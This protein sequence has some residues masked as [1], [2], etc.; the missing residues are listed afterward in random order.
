[1]AGNIDFSEGDFE[2][3][4]EIVLFLKEFSGELDGYL[5]RIN[6]DESIEKKDWNAFLI[7][8]YLS[9]INVYSPY[10]EISTNPLFPPLYKYILDIE[11]MGRPRAPLPSSGPALVFEENTPFSRALDDV[12]RKIFK[13][14][15]PEEENKDEEKISNIRGMLE[16]IFWIESK[17][18]PEER[19]GISAVGLIQVTS[20]VLRDDNIDLDIEWTDDEGKTWK[21]GE[22]DEYMRGKNLSGDS[23]EDKRNAAWTMILEKKREV[24]LQMSAEDQLTKIVLPYVKRQIDIFGLKVLESPL[25]MYLSVLYPK[26]LQ[27]AHLGEQDSDGKRTWILGS[28]ASHKKQRIQSVAKANPLHRPEDV[29]T[30][31]ERNKFGLGNSPTDRDVLRIWEVEEY[32]KRGQKTLEQHKEQY[33][34]PFL[35]KHRDAKRFSG[36]FPEEYER[37]LH[38]SFKS[39]DRTLSPYF[40]RENENLKETHH[41]YDLAY[42]ALLAYRDVQGTLRFA[43]KNLFEKYEGS[44][45]FFEYAQKKARREEYNLSNVPKVKDVEQLMTLFTNKLLAHA[46]SEIKIQ[47]NRDEIQQWWDGKKTGN[48]REKFFNKEGEKILLLDEIFHSINSK[49]SDSSYPDAS[50]EFKWYLGIVRA[51]ILLTVEHALR[52][53]ISPSLSSEEKQIR[54]MDFARSLIRDT[55]KIIDGLVKNGTDYSSDIESTKKETTKIRKNFFVISEKSSSSLTQREREVFNE[56]NLL[57]NKE[58]PDSFYSTEPR[59]FQEYVKKAKADLLLT[60]EHALKHNMNHISS[61]GERK[62]VLFQLM[63]RLILESREIILNEKTEGDNNPAHEYVWDANATG[64]IRK[65]FFEENVKNR[66]VLERA[67]KLIDEEFKKPLYSNEDSGSETFKRYI[68]AA[69]D[70]LKATLEEALKNNIRESDKL[71]REILLLEFTMDLIT[72]GRD[73]V[74]GKKDG[75]TSFRKGAEYWTWSDTMTG[76]IRETFFDFGGVSNNA[77]TE[78]HN[79]IYDGLSPYFSKSSDSFSSQLNAY[80]NHAYL[81]IRLTVRHALNHLDD[82]I[83]KEKVLLAFTRRLVKKSVKILEKNR[84]NPPDTWDGGETRRIRNAFFRDPNN[85]ILKSSSDFRKSMP[86]VEGLRLESQ[87]LPFKP[88]YQPLPLGLTDPLWND[89]HSGEFEPNDETKKFIQR[90]SSDPKGGHFFQKLNELREEGGE[91]LLYSSSLPLSLL[92]ELLY[93]LKIDIEK[94]DKIYTYVNRKKIFRYETINVVFSDGKKATK[95]KTFAQME[96]AL[97]KRRKKV[98]ED[99][100]IGWMTD[101]Q[102]GEVAL[103]SREEFSKKR[104]EL[105]SEQENL[106]LIFLAYENSFGYDT[107]A[108]FLWVYSVNNPSSYPLIE[109]YKSSETIVLYSNLKEKTFRQGEAFMNDG[110]E[111]ERLYKQRRRVLQEAL[112]QDVWNEIW[113]YLKTQKIIFTG[114]KEKQRQTERPSKLKEDWDRFVSDPNAYGQI[115]Q[116]LDTKFPDVPNI[117]K[118]KGTTII[119]S[120]IKDK[121]NLVL[122]DRGKRNGLTSINAPE[123]LSFVHTNIIFALLAQETNF[124]GNGGYGVI[125][126]ALRRNPLVALASFYLFLT[127]N[128]PTNTFQQRSVQR[129]RENALL[130]IKNLFQYAEQKLSTQNRAASVENK[131]GFIRTLHSNYFGAMGP[132]QKIPINIRTK[133][134]VELYNTQDLSTLELEHKKQAY[135]SVDDYFTERRYKIPEISILEEK[136]PL[137]TKKLMHII[138]DYSDFDSYFSPVGFSQ[139]LVYHEGGQLGEN[140]KKNRYTLEELQTVNTYVRALLTYNKST[141]YALRIL[142]TATKLNALERKNPQDRDEENLDLNQRVQDNDASDVS[143]NE[144]V[145]DETS[146]PHETPAPLGEELNLFLLPR[147]LLDFLDTKFDTTS[148]ART[149]LSRIGI[150]IENPSSVTIYNGNIYKI[151]HITH[152]PHDLPFGP[153]EW[154][155]SSNQIRGIYVNGGSVYFDVNNLVLENMANGKMTVRSIESIRFDSSGGVFLISD[156]LGIMFD[157][158]N[159]NNVDACSYIEEKY[160]IHSVD[161]SLYINNF[162]GI[163]G[164]VCVED[165]NITDG[166]Y[167]VFGDSTWHH[168]PEAGVSDAP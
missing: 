140:F 124:F 52:V 42:F 24:I 154:Q 104:R 54:L 160:I 48:M 122:K 94:G 4:K 152:V 72:S 2:R 93:H 87:W 141:D 57:I 56:I 5:S 90:V 46:V 110:G 121:Y 101:D 81:D 10:G 35:P 85:F 143:D 157:G 9:F 66:E 60:G 132:M 26:A 7:K 153:E 123:S 91:K 79:V 20:I 98:F 139:F 103:L 127:P 135:L 16:T 21:H 40:N 162:P 77:L 39:V 73:I 84:G 89:I 31:G 67:F 126:N 107:F 97:E 158:T 112:G 155:W 23:K 6:G 117:G 146:V 116:T 145:H 22:E 144:N 19:N 51:E 70:D 29:L 38:S 150:Q 36:E 128:D 148:R 14:A 71:E 136:F 113:K 58:F 47:E 55:K 27:D 115:G 28:E 92:Q 156:S 25:N 74:Q 1:L 34:N 49:L 8:K 62:R 168:I 45:K 15:Y 167:K 151:E 75:D 17:M 61:P 86:S 111:R 147:A 125:T 99:V 64:D 18:N 59:G 166:T 165:I 13:S 88:W 134:N 68:Q 11:P 83:D 119:T 12:S 82:N 142:Y 130:G 129:T 41:P 65:R 161:S 76:T 133:D 30:L 120:G 96:S 159:I 3:S 109:D 63:N 163:P 37:I 114:I 137:S 102:W 105:F 149:A 44:G 80:V 106:S 95:I 118:Y 33:N 100:N 138:E 43:L 32:V 78:A 108:D 131:I 53:N 69:K 164:D 50:T